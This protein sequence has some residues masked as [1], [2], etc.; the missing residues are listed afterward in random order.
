MRHPLSANAVSPQPNRRRLTPVWSGRR[1]QFELGSDHP[2]QRFNRLEILRRN[3]GLRDCEIEFRFHAEHQI[4]HIHRRQ[5]DIHQS[6]FRINLDGNRV[7][8]EDRLDENQ[9]PVLNVGIKSLHL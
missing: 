2:F 7:L 6:R 1:P 5:P 3:L 4:D 8:F 9:D